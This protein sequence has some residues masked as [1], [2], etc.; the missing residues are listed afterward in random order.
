MCEELWRWISSKIIHTQNSRT[1]KT[2]D[3]HR[4]WT[5]KQILYCRKSYIV[6]SANGSP[7]SLACLTLIFPTQSSSKLSVQWKCAT[8]HLFPK[9]NW[10]FLQLAL[11]P[12]SSSGSRNVVSCLVVRSPMKCISRDEGMY[13]G[14]SLAA[15]ISWPKKHVLMPGLT[16]SNELISWYGMHTS[17]AFGHW[18]CSISY[19]TRHVY[20]NLIRVVRYFP[21]PQ[22]LRY[23][24]QSVWPCIHS[25]F[26]CIE[27]VLPFNFWHEKH[28]HI[29]KTAPCH[30]KKNI[31]WWTP[32]MIVCCE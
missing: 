29:P 13:T 27:A 4:C 9:S 12:R 31:H 10:M 1:H 19:N 28:K 7:N 11:R 22:C 3:T 23:S 14:F 32:W 17:I 2:Y 24:T 8:H 16:F 5:Q 20:M 30:F 25:Y 26:N 21:G 18:Y 15:S 6:A